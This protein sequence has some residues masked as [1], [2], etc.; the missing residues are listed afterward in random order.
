MPDASSLSTSHRGNHGDENER[1][2]FSLVTMSW[3]V[4]AWIDKDD[5]YGDADGELVA[6]VRGGSTASGTESSWPRRIDGVGEGELVDAADRWRQG[7]RARG[8]GGST[9]SGTESSWPRRASI[10]TE[11]RWR[12]MGQLR[13]SERCFGGGFGAAAL[14]GISSVVAR[15]TRVFILF[16]DWIVLF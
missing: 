13:R 12:I 8:R 7:R 11:A 2:G 6:A 16:P 15:R 14:W 5:G 10:L 1:E 9:A 3:A 4:W